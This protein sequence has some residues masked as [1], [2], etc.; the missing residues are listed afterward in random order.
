[1]GAH[2]GALEKLES[3]VGAVI[4]LL[5]EEDQEELKAQL[6]DLTRQYHSHVF[7]SEAYLTE[8]WLE[9]REAELSAMAPTAVQV[10]PLQVLHYDCSAFFTSMGILS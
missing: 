2:R 9:D 8:R 10:T 6:E 4:P 1:M 3:T 5:D 7:D